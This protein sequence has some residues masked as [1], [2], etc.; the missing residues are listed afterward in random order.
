[1]DG[2]F[3]LSLAA[4]L[5]VFFMAVLIMVSRLYRK[6][7]QGRAMIVNTL[8]AE[9]KVTFTGSLVVP[10]LHKMEAM[11]ISLKT[12]E[13]VRE[14]TDGLICQ[15]NIRAD[16]K[17]AF[18]VRVSKSKGDV[19]KVAQAVGCERASNQETL[20][21][22]FSAKFSEALKTVGKSMEFTDLY[23]K[24]DNFRDM[25]ISNIGADLNGYVLEDAAID[26]L[27]QTPVSSLD[28]QNILDSRASARSPS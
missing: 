8:R 9:P 22:L 26:Y 19:L 6:V 27:E 17:V 15:D 5:F 10:V 28:P 16:I 2:G 14:G 18:F 7:E 1:M 25:I 13:I 24:R 11:D 4:G 21:A 12:I 3:W 23:S 20:E